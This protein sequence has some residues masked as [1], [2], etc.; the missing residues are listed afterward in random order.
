MVYYVTEKRASTL[1]V[2]NAFGAHYE[3]WNPLIN[4]FSKYFQV[5]VWEIPGCFEADLSESQ[6][7]LY[8][9]DSQVKD[10]EKVV[11]NEKIDKFHIIAWCSGVKATMIYAHKH[12]DK[13]ES[14]TIIS[15]DFAPFPGYK[16]KG[17]KFRENAEIIM[18]IIRERPQLLS[19]YLKLISENVFYSDKDESF[20]ER[21]PN[22]WHN[23]FLEQYDHKEWAISFL[24]MCM[25]QYNYDISGIIQDINIPIL[26][27]TS[28]YDHVAS[29][30]QSEWAFKRL[31]KGNMVIL[32]MATHL[33]IMER[34]KEIFEI[35]Q[36]EFRYV[37]K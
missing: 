18:K 26:L 6:N 31:R 5:I 14:I 23:I 20:F 17:N 25:G 37:W 2:I 19:I 8:C 3:A 22:E 10:I 15:G 11:S 30:D 24:V 32:P 35:M 33:V 27:I 9:I 28:K 21:V 12:T 29:I 4:Y 34:A 16:W 1:I 36:E 13:I 7:G